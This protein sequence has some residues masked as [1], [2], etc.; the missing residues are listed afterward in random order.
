MTIRV[1]KLVVPR[2]IDHFSSV[3]AVRFVTR[4]TVKLE[5]SIC[6]CD[7]S[8]T[9]RLDFFASSDNYGFQKNSTDSSIVAI[10]V[11]FSHNRSL[12][13]T[14]VDNAESRRRGTIVDKSSGSINSVALIRYG[15]A[16]KIRI[17]HPLFLLSINYGRAWRIRRFDGR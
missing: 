5:A 1:T 2:F 14:S 15:Y 13:R 16:Q 10:A 3:A 7:C 6:G 12:V 4:F 11:R 17:D 8:L 9:L